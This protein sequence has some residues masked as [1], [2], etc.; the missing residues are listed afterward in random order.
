MTFES[1]FTYVVTVLIFLVSP[2]PSHIFMLSKSMANGFERSWAVAAGDLTA[3][4]WQIAAASLGL[5]SL[6]Y[7]FKELFMVIKWAGVL[8]LVYLGVRQF[9]RK[10]SLNGA[11]G[12]VPASRRTLFLQGFA[13]SSSNP[14]AVVFF[15]ALFPQFINTSQPASIQFA[16]LGATYIF[17]DGCFLA[18]Y[19]NFADWCQRRFERYLHR[20]LNRFAGTL[21]IVSA[22]MLGLKDVN[23]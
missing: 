4:L 10:S 1:W 15:A 21:M 3:H 9:M 23:D 14:K 8:F 20:Y 2:G 16:I 19:G 6:I 5:V 11:G 17:I 12:E 13:M 18:F 7:A 22:I